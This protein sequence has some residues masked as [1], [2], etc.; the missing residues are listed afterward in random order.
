[1]NYTII[2]TNTQ[3]HNELVFLDKHISTKLSLDN[4]CK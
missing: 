4:W 3:G 1:M 2:V